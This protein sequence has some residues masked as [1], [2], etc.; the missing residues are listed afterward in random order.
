MRCPY[1]ALLQLKVSAAY[2]DSAGGIAT[3]VH[4]AVVEIENYITLVVTPLAQ[5]LDLVMGLRRT[6][7]DLVPSALGGG[8]NGGIV[9]DLQGNGTAVGNA[10]AILAGL[11]STLQSVVSVAAAVPANATTVLGTDYGL[12]AF[13]RQFIAAT[14]ATAA[15]FQADLATGASDALSGAL[16]V[17]SAV[18]EHELTAPTSA[19]AQLNAVSVAF[20]RAGA[21][22]ACKDLAA[23]GVANR[24][25]VGHATAVTAHVTRHTVDVADA[26]LDRAVAAVHAAV[27]GLPLQSESLA[28]ATLTVTCV[29]CA[30]AAFRQL[31]RQLASVGALLAPVG[32]LGGDLGTLSG[33]FAPFTSAV[34]GNV[35]PLVT[36]LAAALD[37]LTDL[38]ASM[39]GFADVGLSFDQARDLDDMLA[40]WSAAA[41]EVAV[42]AKRAPVLAASLSQLTGTVDTMSAVA[43]ACAGNG[44]TGSGGMLALVTA[45]TSYGH[46]LVAMQ[47]DPVMDAFRLVTLGG[48]LFELIKPEVVLLQ[49]YVHLAE[50]LIA[51]FEDTLVEVYD[52]VQ[53]IAAY[54]AAF[55]S[56]VDL[57]AQLAVRLPTCSAVSDG[58]PCLHTLPRMTS[59]EHK[60]LFPLSFAMLYLDTKQGAQSVTVPGLYDGYSLCGTS[61]IGSS[62]SR[63]IV[64][65]YNSVPAQHGGKTLPSLLVVHTN[66]DGNGNG[67]SLLRVFELYAD[68][69]ATTALTA[70]TGVAVTA[71]Y[72][73]VA[74]AQSGGAVYAYSIATVVTSAD[75]TASAV[76]T[77][78]VL[79]PSYY[80]GTNPQ[81]LPFTPNGGLSFFVQDSIC[82][83][84]VSDGGDGDGATTVPYTFNALCDWFTS[85]TLVSGV[86][87]VTGAFVT[88]FV[89][90][91]HIDTKLY[92]TLLRCTLTP[93]YVCRLEFC[94]LTHSGDSTMG[95]HF[96][97]QESVYQVDSAVALT[98]TRT[99]WSP[100]PILARTL[101]VQ[102]VLI[103]PY[104]R[105][106]AL[107]ICIFASC[108][109][110]R[111]SVLFLPPS[112]HRCSHL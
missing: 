61:F 85:S 11:R 96:Q 91:E 92:A 18:L 26:A 13:Q 34:V 19:W 89:V 39:G 46:T 32:T 38:D 82:I 106:L 69:D 6:V 60:L 3:K 81:P 101:V 86:P 21:R 88:G 10:P 20:T 78:A 83:M 35:A 77:P 1:F 23:A 104:E 57:S 28:N 95:F 31:Q 64:S 4:D 109:C 29:P 68:G 48:G 8:T 9:T 14:N 43:S 54:V 5:G 72:V 90:F 112:H 84:F 53:A 62:N 45:I 66:V 80:G 27:Q 79:S 110:L 15:L 40:L 42:A 51:R 67:G 24:A 47:A 17:V 55:A 103:S 76:L 74:A 56:G 33:A 94:P 58:Q 102:D 99:P 2:P 100:P 44:T 73:A 30:V 50:R 97:M 108:L 36:G 49:G 98:L 111:I 22:Q 71:V 93:S 52:K 41:D 25:V 107:P 70:V 87:F 16:G 105:F 63:L 59:W 7:M 75:G 37:T 65:V 12:L